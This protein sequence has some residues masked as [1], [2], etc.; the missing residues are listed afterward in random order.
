MSRC[1][2]SLPWEDSVFPHSSSI[3]KVTECKCAKHWNTK[4]LK[5]EFTKWCC[6]VLLWVAWKSLYLKQLWAVCWPCWW[7][8]ASLHYCSVMQLVHPSDPESCS[9]MQS[10]NNWL[11]AILPNGHHSFSPSFL[12]GR[13]LRE[14]IRKWVHFKRPLQMNGKI[15]TCLPACCSVTSRFQMLP[16]CLMMRTFWCEIDCCSLPL[17]Q[18]EVY[19]L[20]DKLN[21]SRP[22]RV[23]RKAQTCSRSH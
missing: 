17:M 22:K 13:N 3:L 4:N 12:F 23:S 10:G 2:L 18:F 15:K 11:T 1:S 14:S 21:L 9:F 20:F 16:L 6:P 8:S 7:R 19:F 5:Y